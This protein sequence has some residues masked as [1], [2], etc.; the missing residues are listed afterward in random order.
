MQR[1]KFYEESAVSNRSKRESKL[2]TAFLVVAVFFFIIGGI[3][4]FFS[5]SQIS[6]TLKSTVLNTNGKV[7]YIVGWIAMLVMD[8]I[9]GIVLFRLKNRFNV[10]YDYTYVD[11]EV[12]FTKVFN[13]RRRKHIATVTMDNLL[14]IGYCDKPSYEN[15]LRELR[16]R[17]PN[18][19]TPNKT[20]A[21]E[22]F[23]IYLL[24]N[25]SFERKIYVLECRKEMLEYL[26]FAAGRNK[27]VSE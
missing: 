11:D 14:R 16:G 5:Y 12:R 22:K 13:G 21:E 25:T 24:V 18:I 26:V 10:S 3:M 1:D 19:L 7:V 17:K 6:N 23:R 15:A 20:P 9:I 8:L 4:V 27:W 2:Y